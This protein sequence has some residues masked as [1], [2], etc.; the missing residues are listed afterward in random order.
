MSAVR[1]IFLLS[2][3]WRMTF[4]YGLNA[5][6]DCMVRSTCC[7]LEIVNIGSP[8]E[9][10]SGSFNSMD[11]LDSCNCKLIAGNAFLGA[12]VV[13]FFNVEALL[14]RAV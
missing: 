10:S 3:I 1:A 11:M 14:N 7:F 6:S 9:D 13:I 8:S 5:S 4:T 2:E 12:G